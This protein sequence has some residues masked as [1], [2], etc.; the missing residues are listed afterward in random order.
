MLKREELS[1]MLNDVNKNCIVFLHNPQNGDCDFG[2]IIHICT[3]LGLCFFNCANKDL[4]PSMLENLKPMYIVLGASENLDKEY[5]ETLCDN[6]PNSFVFLF[7]NEN[8]ASEK[9][10]CM[11]VDGM[12]SLCEKIRN[13]H[14]YI[15]SHMIDFENN[16]KLF[17]NY[18]LLELDK[19]S[20]R[21][22]LIGEKYLADLIYEF[23]FNSKIVKNKCGNAY[24]ILSKRYDTNPIARE[25]LIRFAI[26]KAFAHSQDKQLFYD[27]SKKD[28]LP[29]IKELAGYI[30]NKLVYILGSNSADY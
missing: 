5:V 26:T 8:F 23:Y 22:K 1:K 7:E 4:L 2:E 9:N 19:L 13:H 21:A 6:Y 30:T 18:I 25:R 17:Y 15:Q 27:I 3:K 16:S 24:E 29:S 10:N 11:N 14:K 28:R 12:L 20:F